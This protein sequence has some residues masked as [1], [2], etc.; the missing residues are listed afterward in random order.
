MISGWSLGSV[1]IASSLLA[2]GLAVAQ[3]PQPTQPGQQLPRQQPQTQQQQPQQQ[4][5]QQLQRQQQQRQA[6]QGSKILEVQ[7]D[8][9]TVTD[10]QGK[11]QTHQ[12]SEN[13]RVTIDGKQAR[14]QD[15]KPGDRV[16]ITRAED[17]PNQ[18]IAISAMRESG[19]VAITSRRIGT[20]R[21][22][23]PK[24][25]IQM[26]EK[27][28]TGRALRASEITGME[29][30]N[31]QGE[32]LGNIEDLM[33]DMS[34]GQIRYAVLSFG[35]FLGIGDKL[36]AV[37]WNQFRLAHERDDPDEFL[38]VLD[39]P[40]SRLENAPGFNEESWPATADKSYWS[41]VDTFYGTGTRQGTG[42]DSGT[43][44]PRGGTTAPRQQE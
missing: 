40:K 8:Q 30:R 17:N 43:S 24:V 20:E 27:A 3:Q 31:S 4:Q 10:A 15:L 33:I 18:V 14:L 25:G 12:I 1:T 21:E 32:D 42:T 39:V 36:F 35:G 9:L 37:P 28:E 16:N 2:V 29:V 5:G 22:R 13:I 44:A 7:D 34:T 38:F 11:K 6:A 41:D 23:R 26:S 19:P